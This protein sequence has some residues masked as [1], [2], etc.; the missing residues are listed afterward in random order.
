MAK[1][2]LEIEN[3]NEIVIETEKGKEMIEVK[4]TVVQDIEMLSGQVHGVEFLHLSDVDLNRID[5]RLT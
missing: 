4:E 3:E 1:I 5:M 2:G